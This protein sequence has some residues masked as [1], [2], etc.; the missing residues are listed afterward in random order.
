M[1]D[2]FY[3]GCCSTALIDKV[4]AKI[5]VFLLYTRWFLWNSLGGMRS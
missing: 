5:I 2:A 4:K 1:S 3:E